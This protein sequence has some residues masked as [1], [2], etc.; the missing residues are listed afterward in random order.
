MAREV[1]E[2][3][4]RV[5]GASDRL[6]FCVFFAI[7]VHATFVLGVSFTIEPERMA[8]LTVE[9]SLAQYQDDEEPEE[10]D[11]LAQAN[12]K[13]SGTEEEKR[14]ITVKEQAEFRDVKPNEVARLEPESVMPKKEVAGRQ[15]VVTKN[16]EVEERSDRKP[17]KEQ[18]VEQTK[19]EKRTLLQRSLE[20]ASLEAKLSDQKQAYAKRPRVTRLTAVSAR[21]SS[22]A[23]YMYEW[24]RNLERIGNI[25]YPEE[26]RRKKLKGKVRFL[27][28]INHDGSVKEIEILQSSG[29]RVLDEAA[30][31]IIKLAAPFPPFTE[32]MRKETDILEIIRT[33]DF[34]GRIS[35][36]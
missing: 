7:A 25:N 22:S 23:F 20:I 10:A 5:V 9:V 30:V 32:K 15:V 35:S 6:S 2:S 27:A 19:E 4:E 18:K 29:Y 1:L 14:E 21:K 26:A 13:G 12:Q 8:P 24:I 17:E 33:F 3:A 11:F 31:R 34:R 16:D 28:S 36:F